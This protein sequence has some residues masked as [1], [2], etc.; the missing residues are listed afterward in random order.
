MLRPF[1]MAAAIGALSTQLEINLNLVE[2][3]NEAKRLLAE[4]NAGLGSKK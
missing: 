1:I 2:A 4:L 3:E